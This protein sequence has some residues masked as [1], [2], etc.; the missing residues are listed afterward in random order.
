MENSTGRYR[1]GK[2]DSNNNNTYDTIYIDE[3]V[4]LLIINEYNYIKYNKKYMYVK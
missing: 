4:K 1:L 2:T 3:W